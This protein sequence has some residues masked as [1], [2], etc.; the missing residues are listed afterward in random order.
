MKPEGI[1]CK[2]PLETVEE[3][4]DIQEAAMSLASAKA[5]SVDAA[6][7]VVLDSIFTSV[8]AGKDIF[9]LLLTGTL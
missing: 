7:V 9:A 8:I 5:I 2:L 6:V 4:E 1:C 3:E